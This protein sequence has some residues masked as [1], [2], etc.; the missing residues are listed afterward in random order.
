M[1]YHGTFIIK[2]KTI[3]WHVFIYIDRAK[4]SLVKWYAFVCFGLERHVLV[5]TGILKFDSA[6]YTMIYIF[7][8]NEIECFLVFYLLEVQIPMG[9]YPNF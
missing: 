7:D 1:S 4:S 2:I 8:K 5:F 3:K 9:Y 6:L